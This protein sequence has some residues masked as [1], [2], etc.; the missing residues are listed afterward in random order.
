MPYR[1]VAMLVALG[2]AL[3]V[4]V[5]SAQPSQAPGNPGTVLRFTAQ[6]VLLDFIARDKHQKLVTDLR[7]ED[8]EILEDGI[9]QRARS[10]QYRHGFDKSARRDEPAHARGGGNMSYAPLGEINVV[11][12]VFERLSP[13]CR[14]QAGQPPGSAVAYRW[15]IV[16]AAPSDGSA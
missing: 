5:G 16:A 7:P 10:F 12:L 9:P 11:S 3:A 13:D 14:R 4:S 8:I 1:A 15:C 6:E 2:V